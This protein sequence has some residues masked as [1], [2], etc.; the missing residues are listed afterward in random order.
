MRTTSVAFGL[1]VLIWAP[2]CKGSL[3]SFWVGDVGCDCSIQQQVAKT[4]GQIGDAEGGIDFA[5]GLGDMFYHTSNGP[6]GIMGD[7]NDKRFYTTFENTYDAASLR[8]T[9]WYVTMGN[10]DYPGNLSAWTAHQHFSKRWYFPHTYYDRIIPMP[11]SGYNATLHLIN[12]DTP[13]LLSYDQNPVGQPHG[14]TVPDPK[15]RQEF[16]YK[17]GQMKKWL[18]KTLAQ[19]TADWIVAFGHHHIWSSGQYEPMHSMVHVL[20]PLFE[21]YGVVAYFNGHDHNMQHHA[22][23]GVSYFV[24]G[25]GGLNVCSDKYKNRPPPGSKKFLTC[26]GGFADVQLNATY[27][28][29][30]FRGQN[31]QEL[32]SFTT[33]NPRVQKGIVAAQR[34]PLPPQ[35]TPPSQSPRPSNSSSPTTSNPSQ[36]PRPSNRSSPIIL[37]PSPSSSPSPSPNSSPSP[38]SGLQPMTAEDKAEILKQLAATQQKLADLHERLK[39]ANIPVNP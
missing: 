6:G 35:P 12:I 8:N 14:R 34:E 4:M 27:F 19:S 30:K 10:H 23:N 32:Y 11:K 21:K 38:S 9:T 37:S 7:G 15:E 29:M 18:E 3:R 36:S 20:P 5:V 33:G 22:V 13:L 2:P 1:W 31:G 17:A 28:H 26:G 16:L 39:K 25:N 24:N